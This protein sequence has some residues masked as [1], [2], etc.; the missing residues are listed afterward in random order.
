MC[1]VYAQNVQKLTT[2]GAL[3]CTALREL[4]ALRPLA[5][6]T[7]GQGSDRETGEW[8]GKRKGMGRGKGGVSGETRFKGSSCDSRRGCIYSSDVAYLDC[9]FCANVR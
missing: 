6:C 2:I 9:S 1:F 3:P 8:R 7:V 5:G 4:T